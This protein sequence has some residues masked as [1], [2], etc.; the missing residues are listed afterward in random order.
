LHLGM[1]IENRVRRLPGTAVKVSEYRYVP[2]N[3]LEMVS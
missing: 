2:S 1:V 3:L